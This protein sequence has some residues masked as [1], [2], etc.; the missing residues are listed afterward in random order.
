MPTTSPTSATTYF[1]FAE[2]RWASVQSGAHVRPQILRLGAP[3]DR[4]AGEDAEPD[5]GGAARHP[6]PRRDRALLRGRRRRRADDTRPGQRVE[7]HLEEARLLALA[8]DQRGLRAPPTGRRH[9]D[10]MAPGIERHG[11]TGLGARVVDLELRLRE[12]VAFLVD[13]GEDDRGE[14]PLDVGEP[15]RAALLHEARTAIL[16]AGEELRPRLRERATS[17][18]DLTGLGVR[19][20][21]RDPFRACRRRDE[22]ER[23]DER[24]TLHF[25][26][27]GLKCVIPFPSIV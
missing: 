16:R 13:D 21:A 7:L 12:V 9:D 14:L 8:R 5:H 3:R 22:D 24:A 1:V 17:L 19:D 15:P 2:S 11:A 23:D 20:A 18:R 4:E 26:H 27:S 25:T 6:R 10:A